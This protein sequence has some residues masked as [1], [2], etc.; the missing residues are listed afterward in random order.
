MRRSVKVSLW[1]LGILAVLP[2]LLAAVVLIAAN[3]QPGR[4]LIQRLVPQV[5]GGMVKLEGLGGSIPAAFRAARIEVGDADGVWLVIEHLTL[6]WTPSRLLTGEA[7]IDRLS[8][9]RIGLER[10]PT[11]S[12]ETSENSGVNLPLRVRLKSLEVAKLELAAAV[13]GA[14]ES[15][16]IKGHARLSSFTQG[17]VVLDVRELEGTGSYQLDGKFDPIALEGNLTAE[18]PA[19]GPLARLAGL[20]DLGAIVMDGA[21]KGPHSAVATDLSL[22]A[23][24]LSAQVQGKLD[25]Q[26]YA[27]DLKVTASAPAMSPRPDLSWQEVSLDATLS[28]YFERP[29]AVGSL[30][31]AA[32]Q[33]GGA[34]IRDI[35]AAV[36][37]DVGQLQLKASLDGLRIPGERPELLAA[38]PLT[39]KA[40]A[41]LDKPERPVTFELEHPLIGIQGDARTAGAIQAAIS[42]SL[43]DV[44]PL[45]AAAGVDLQGHSYLELQV[46]E[47]AGATTLE[48]QGG[49]AITG[50]VSPVP[51]LLG[52]S[53][54]ILASAALDG[55]ELTLSRLQLDGK[56]IQFSADGGLVSQVA[57]L[58]WQ[59]SLSDLAQ[60]APTLSGGLHAKGRVNGPVD[61]LSAT[62]DLNGELATKG[63][64]SAPLSAHVEAKGIPSAPAGEMKAQGTIAGSPLDLSIVAQR[65]ADGTSRL[66]IERA[67]WKSAH[68]EGKMTLPPGSIFPVGSLDLGMTRL[69]DLEPLLQQSPTGALTAKLETTT[70]DGESRA[71]ITVEARAA[72]LPGIGAVKKLSLAAT[73]VDPVTSLDLD[74][75][76]IV[77]G[78]SAQGISGSGRLEA[79]GPQDAL[80][81]Q[82]AAD[83]RDPAGTPLR[84]T[85]KAVLDASGKKVALDKLQA[86]WKG[87]TLRLLSPAKIAFG[88]EIGMEDIQVGIRDAVLKVSGGISPALDLT[89][90]VRNL[91]P[92]LASAF[93]PDLKAE[94]NLRADAKVSGT[95]AKPTGTVRVQ[96]SGLRIRSGPAGSLPAAD[97]KA[98]ATLA[99]ESA[100]IDGRLTLGPKANLTLAGQAPLSATG[101]VDLRAKGSADL[102][103]TDPIITAGGRLVRGQVQLNAGVSGTLS[104]P[105]LSG[106][107][108]LVQGEVQ[109]YALGAHL[110]DIE[111]SFQ[112]EGDQ[113]RIAR[114][115]AHAGPGTVSGSGTVGI[116]QRDIPVDLR[117]EAQNA[118]PLSSDL[119]TADLDASLT[120][121][122]NLA[123]R[124]LVSGNI[125]GNRVEI[126]IP[127][128]LP[129]S[130]AT[131]D[132]RR[133]GEKP[134]ARTA[135]GPVIGLDLSIDAPRR[136]FVRG[137][138][139]DAE[140]GG[141]VRVQG[142]LV[143]PRPIGS[144][145]LLRGQFSLTGKT[146]D[147]SK[148]KVS[149]NGG[150]LTNPSLDFEVSR[151][152]ADVTAKLGI[153]GTVRKP[154]ISLSSTPDLPDQEILAE[155]LFGKSASSLSAVELAQIASALGELTG[156]VPSVNLLSG[157]RKG[158]GLDELTVGTDASGKATLEAGEYIAPNVYVGVE[159]GASAGSTRAK[160][161]VDLT[162]GLKLE[163]TVG[164][165]SGSATGSSD[166]GGSS[167]GV[168][169]E[170]EY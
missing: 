124:L 137:R 3:T 20:E 125:Q 73:V 130:V 161:Q 58:S 157:I 28:G 112:L 68:G 55:Q 145:E 100:R 94:G 144:F 24:P 25:L 19:N 51:G 27:A 64:P 133:P 140:V 60:L 146:L 98:T 14:A 80:A 149:F 101:R 166:E 13:A 152:D 54:K 122:G 138:G 111:A 41:R 48:A 16:S 153:G 69:Q 65:S 77:D 148:G 88:E 154:K 37:G 129:T 8:A 78:F 90:Q 11:E 10:L 71:Q 131:L 120:A 59:L 132:V 9:G 95:L 170:F 121:Q 49:I 119:L 147:F 160:V 116:L 163:G 155:L 32:L 39:I 79:K 126:R 67:D 136:I 109:D 12:S 7:L 1:T 141:K 164:A 29:T 135:P 83:A 46:G 134:S 23:G 169:Y 104:S 18:E 97:L 43:P 99:G 114:L 30:H 5:T 53:A 117:L 81:L 45:A 118:R 57:D 167:I 36:Q 139:L 93:F 62:A 123:K 33:A 151:S 85:G 66:D 91:S 150:S 56:S 42:V 168:T 156:V 38:A 15:F 6:D 2:I 75:K 40:E 142:T 26:D 107:I 63:F 34:E 143:D 21:L 82:I 35:A 96:A 162:K 108:G 87:E 84:L 92:A 44:A 76:L 102:S 61:D 50:G 128:T 110:E 113:V 72:G 74:A 106:T 115:T 70:E 47:R 103:L 4:D 52:D 127:E 86:S 165:S 31:I 17:D 89:A 159:Q 22:F 105:R 158:L